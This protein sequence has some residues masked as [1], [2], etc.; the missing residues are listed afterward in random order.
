MKE[1][2]VGNHFIYSRESMKS[3]SMKKF[4]RGE[5]NGKTNEIGFI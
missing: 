3:F 5:L 1:K 2:I 4:V